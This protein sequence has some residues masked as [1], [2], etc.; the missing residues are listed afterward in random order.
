MCGRF[1]LSIDASFPTRFG[2]DGLDFGFKSRFNIFPDSIIPTITSSNKLKMMKWGLIPPWSEDGKSFVIN[3]RFETITEKPL[4][5]K[6][7]DKKRCLIPTTGYYEWQKSADKSK[8]PFFI[9]WRDEKYHAFA[10]IWDLWENI[11]GEE[12]FSCSIITSNAPPPLSA[13][14]DRIPLILDKNSEDIWL[15]EKIDFQEASSHLHS[16]ESKNIQ[17]F[18]V[19]KEVNDP[20]HDSEILTQ[21]LS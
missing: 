18:P 9:T 1:A 2:V 8:T 21:P 20:S 5:K 17:F 14:H 11:T 4:F 16:L 3:S 15:D 19:S 12:I 7:I 13:I 6:L 10:G